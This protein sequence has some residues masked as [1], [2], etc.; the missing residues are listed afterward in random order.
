M[1]LRRISQMKSLLTSDCLKT[2]VISLVL[3]RLD[4]CN[5]LLVG[6]TDANIN[7]LQRV[8]NCAARLVLGKS[9]MDSRS[10][11]LLQTLHWLPVR[12]RIDY[13]IGLLCYKS[14]KSTAPSYIKDLL[15]PYE[16]TRTL[17]SQN[18]KLLKIPKTNLRR[19][20]DRSFSKVGP[21]KWNDLP[22]SVRSATSLESFKKS[23]KTHL[24]KQCFFN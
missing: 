10:R 21:K 8:Q 6:L 23:L 20:G 16:P 2:L 17:R 18:I 7:K 24:F 11:D 4:Y 12:A 19:F 3:S 15:V 13:K 9:R 14:L 1:E 22:L 5:S